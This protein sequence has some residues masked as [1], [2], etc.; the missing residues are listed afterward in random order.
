MHHELFTHLIN[1][2]DSPLFLGVRPVANMH[3]MQF[4]NQTVLHDI[5]F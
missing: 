2:T 5:R 1:S 4:F 3:L